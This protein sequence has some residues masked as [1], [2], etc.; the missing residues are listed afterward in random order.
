MRQKLIKNP[1]FK[2]LSSIKI[3]VACLSLL[4]VL[5]FWGTIDQTFNGL[6]HAQ[7]TFFHSWFFWGFGF[8]PLPGAQLVLWVLFINL[9]CVAIT[10]FVYRASHIGILVLHFGLLTY[11]ISAFVTLNGVQESNLNLLEGAS[12]NISSAYHEWELSLWKQERN[13]KQVTAFDT[14][15]IKPGQ[16]LDFGNDW[17]VRV[18]AYYPNS[19]AYTKVPEPNPKIFSISG[20]QELKQVATFNEPE[21]NL[22]GGTFTIDGPKSQGNVLLYGGETTPTP[23]GYDHFI[24]LRKKKFPMPFLL[25]LIDFKMEKHPN[26]EI[27]RRYE[28]LVEITHENVARQVVISM[29]KPLRFKDFTVYQASYAIDALGREYSTL[30]VVKNSG[31]LLPYIAS[32]ITF[33]GLALHFL[34]M[35]LAPRIK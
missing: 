2:F 18:R 14:D 7:E 4:F 17:K 33:V 9:V 19:Q 30:A 29:N 32:G 12:S 21:K 23:L 26:T 5:T 15:G 22:P 11:F 24:Q 28:S 1:V 34:F 16:M 31:R 35:A 27:A 10:R 20:I 13:T 8:L 3:T 25:K 6:Y